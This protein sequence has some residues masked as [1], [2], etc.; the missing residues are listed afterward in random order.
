MSLVSSVR[1]AKAEVNYL[2][3]AIDRSLDLISFN[4]DKSAKKA[5]IKPNLCY[6]SDYSTGRTTNPLF[7]SAV[8][9]MLRERISSDL[10]ISIVESD[11]T[12]MKC[13]HVFRF[14]GYDNMAKEKRV[15]LVNLT[16]DKFE[17]FEVGTA[18]KSFRFKLPET[19]ARADLLVN[20]PVIKL[21]D[22]TGIS[23][24]LKNVYGCNPYPKK[25]RYHPYLD[26]AIV[27]LNKAIK[28]DLC[29]IDATIVRGIIPARLGL[30]IASMDPVAADVVAS[31]IMNINSTKIRHIMLA[32]EEMVGNIHYTL[33]GDRLPTLK[34]WAPRKSHQIRKFVYSKILRPIYYSYLKPF[35]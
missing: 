33:R 3:K 18:K 11:A 7:V 32:F 27:C 6:Y 4:F 23:C 28:F 9:D 13:K 1:V 29:L 15:S 25:V 30:I 24:A 21:H 34:K 26:E 16:A 10:Q 2:A 8:I 31:E 14:L 19:I 17:E 20:A 35:E 12:A 5:V 22:L